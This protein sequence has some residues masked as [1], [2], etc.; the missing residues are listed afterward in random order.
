[1]NK[2]FEVII[3]TNRDTILYDH[4]RAEDERMAEI[5]ATRRFMIDQK[6]VRKTFDIID[7][8]VEEI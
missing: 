2:N 8:I 1:M 5:I 7:I 3:K 6:D 4:I